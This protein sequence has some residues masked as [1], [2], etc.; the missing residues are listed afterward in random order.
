[1]RERGI[2]EN[3]GALVKAAA[4]GQAHWE[5]DSESLRFGCAAST[6]EVLSGAVPVSEG[7]KLRRGRGCTAMCEAV[8]MEASADPTESCGTE[9]TRY[10]CP[11]R[12]KGAGHLYPPTNQ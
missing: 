6:G 12:G 8:A 10:Y 4:L 5:T 7:R 1:M 3:F 11:I 2:H 9:I